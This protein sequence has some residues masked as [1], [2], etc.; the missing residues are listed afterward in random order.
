ML[1]LI[2]YVVPWAYWQGKNWARVLVLITSVVTILNLCYRN[3]SSATVLQ[4]HKRVM[5]AY[6][7]VPPSLSAVLAEHTDSPYIFKPRFER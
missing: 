2:G 1:I 4:T 6:E 5:L 3:L 7:V